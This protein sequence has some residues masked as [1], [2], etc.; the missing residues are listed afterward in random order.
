[1]TVCNTLNEMFLGCNTQVDRNFSGT[2]MKTK[3]LL[4]SHRRKE[5]IHWRNL[6]F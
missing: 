1:M 6:K 2:L 3:L 5:Y 4:R